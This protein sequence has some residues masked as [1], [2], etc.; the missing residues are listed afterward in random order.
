[1]F[2]LVFFIAEPTSTPET[3]EMAWIYSM[4]AAVLTAWFRIQF[5]LVEAA[6]YAVLF[7][8]L[9]TWILEQFQQRTNRTRSKLVFNSIIMLWI[10][11]LLLTY[12]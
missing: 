4:V 1:M 8:Q 3:K 10:I 12:L 7:A 2:M 5:D 9:L 11:V 6:I